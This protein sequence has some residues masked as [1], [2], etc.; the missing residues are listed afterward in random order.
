MSEFVSVVFEDQYFSA[1]N[2]VVEATLLDFRFRMKSFKSVQAELASFQERG[3]SVK[4]DRGEE[5]KPKQSSVSRPT[6]MN[7]DVGP[8]QDFVTTFIPTTVAEFFFADEK[9][10]LPRYLDL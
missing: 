4:N 8:G 7:P 10:E 9:G 5:I 2:C 1:L 6:M 3:I